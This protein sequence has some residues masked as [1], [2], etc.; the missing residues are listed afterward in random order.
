MRA[1]LRLP[2]ARFCGASLLVC[3]G[4]FDPGWAQTVLPDGPGKEVV[5]SLCAQC[6]GLDQVTS[7]HR[8]R[9]GWR[10]S[11]ESMAGYGAT[12]TAEE[13]DI[14]VDYLA[15]HFGREAPPAAASIRGT[16]EGPRGVLA[17]AEVKLLQN[18]RELQ[19]AHSSDQG[20]FEFLG[21]SPGVYHLQ[22]VLAPYP[23][24]LQEVDLR[25]PAAPAAVVRVTMA[26]LAQAVTVTAGRIQVP[27][28]SAA[29]NVRI[30]S[31]D[32]LRDA[33]YVALDDRLRSFPE[34]SLF[35]RASS[36]VAHP[37]TQ[38]VSLRGIG[39]SGVSRSLVLLDGVPLNDAFGGWVYWDRVPMAGIQQVEVAS[40]G[41]TSSYGNYGLGGA[42]Q[43]LRRA[44]T[45][46]TL[47]LQLQGG[48]RS[49]RQVQFLASHRAGPWGVAASGAYFDFDGYP[50]VAPGQR[51]A[52]DIQATSSHEATRVSLEL[53]P[54]RSSLVWSLHA[55]HLR[56]D[57]GNGTPLARNRT[58]SFDFST[59]LRWS[60]GPQDHLKARSFFRRTIFNSNYSAV[61]EDRNSERLTTQQTV[62]SID[63]GA[64]LQWD[65]TRGRFSAAA[66]GDLWLVSG[67]S[68]DS[69]VAAGPTITLIREGGGKQATVGVF[70]EGSLALSDRATLVAGL[71][72]DLWRNFEGRLGS[73]VP[74]STPQLPAVA[75]ATK[76]EISPSAGITFDATSRI[77][78]YGSVYRS[79][80]APTLNELYRGF[81]V[82][83]IVTNPNTG[84]VPE[85]T[86]GGEA[87]GRIRLLEELRVELS[88]FVNRL[89]N[90]VSN[91]TQQITA[92]QTVRQRQNLGH[93]RI[94]G[95]QSTVA[96]QPANGAEFGAVYLWDRAS[97]T[98]FAA[99]PELVGKRLPQVPEHR[100]TL[101]ADVSLPNLA[102]ISIVGRFVGEQ[103][104]DDRNDVVLDRFFQ[105]DANIARDLG[106]AARIF[107]SLENVT[108]ARILTARSPVDFIGTPF[109]VRGG[110]LL[111]WRGG[112]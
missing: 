52:V 50:V 18:G 32:D 105:L 40:G 47:E 51:G 46:A 75:D 91:V 23:P 76:V 38:G 60:P 44:P 10:S 88:G 49:S 21:L 90:P 86:V 98:E 5:E 55:G 69:V 6:H 80:R 57:R 62:P 87:G 77:S 2:L 59:E 95:F 48:N 14:V 102:Q 8:T 20:S 45:P 74:G 79:F 39:P 99:D 96:W 110:V 70:G 19:L 34:F 56:E 26:P 112:R 33:P 89:E 16:V 35:R 100:L 61:S 94:Y 11:V 13:I 103:F 43:L 22:A 53:A 84:L 30:L 54:A 111:R 4:A 82:G 93:A 68:A 83:N 15:V 106:T 27:I 71:R 3:L 108:D 109:L 63:G 17:G 107:V 97:V 81:R 31:E 67:A 92:S 65:L 28:T 104:D 24:V 7:L 78:L 73:Y 42:V 36:L 9:Q 85:H 29:S 25:G 66:G 72:V 1:I 37:T 12:F 64:S 58:R 101:S 41:Q